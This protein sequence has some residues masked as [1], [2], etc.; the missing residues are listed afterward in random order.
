MLEVIAVKRSE[1][2][3]EVQSNCQKICG[4]L[5]TQTA[6]PR[7]IDMESSLRP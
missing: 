7:P 2:G 4:N 6:G 1:D 5:L 3:C